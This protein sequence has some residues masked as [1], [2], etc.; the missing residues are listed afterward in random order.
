MFKHEL[1]KV[2][3]NKASIAFVIVVFIINIFQL[4]W[5]EDNSYWYP[6]EAYCS[7]WDDLRASAGDS[8]EGWQSAVDGLEAEI[9]KMQDSHYDISVV[10]S[11]YTGSLYHDSRLYKRVIAEIESTLGY[12]EYLVEIELTKKRY[13]ALGSLVDR[14]NYV[15]RNLMKSATLYEGLRPIELVLEQS[16]GVTMATGSDVTDFLAFALFL[17]F[18]INVW[19]KEKEQGM[20]GVIRTAKNGRARLA[21]TKIVTL[22]MVCVSCSALL[23]ISNM[24]IAEKYYGLGDLSRSIVTVDEYRGTLWRISVKDFLTYNLAFKLVTFVWLALFMSIICVGV[25]GSMAAFGTIAFMCAGS[26]ALYTK[27][28]ALSAWAVFKYLNPFGII[29]TELIFQEFRG[30]NIFGWPFDYRKC[31]AVMLVTGFILFAF[32]TVRLFVRMPVMSVN[33]FAKLTGRVQAVFIK[34]RRR[35]ECHVSITGHEFHRIFV[36]G[37]II[38]VVLVAL[39]I[40]VSS[41]KAY[42][43]GYSSLSEYF[44]R[45]YLEELSGAVTDEKVAFIASEEERLLRPKDENG[46]EQKKAL[47]EIQSRLSYLEAHEGT[48]FV[49]D[50]P[51]NK[52][53]AAD[54]FN[55]DLSQAVLFIIL[56]A[57]SMPLFFAPEWQTGMRKV[58]SVT[59]HGRRRLV[60]IRHVMGVLLVAAFFLITYLPPFIKIFKSYDMEWEKFAY[61]AGSLPHL[62]I[63]GTG[64]SIGTYMVLVYALRLAMGVLAALFIYKLSA[65][66]KSH[67]YTM[68]VA[69]IMLIPVLLASIDY[70][71]E[72]VAYPLSA[73][74]GNMAMQS[75]MAALVCATTATL[76]TLV[77]WI[78]N[79][80]RKV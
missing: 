18:G 17:F 57:L 3:C 20:L 65:L 45:Y 12:E 60:N 9:E 26:Y 49:Y 43:V 40:Q 11:K 33:Y 48:Y 59:L 68:V 13:E 73:F 77:L 63:F 50:E 35:L 7:L 42:T 37:G 14:D 72:F 44:E 5:L 52:L 56:L 36:S 70:K 80:R 54:R 53:T 16:A 79:K 41:N 8:I 46:Q 66:I 71:L 76:V 78:L 27:I 24:V 62:E 34:A 38:L 15:Y 39:V 67:V 74:A 51:F 22:V 64:M 19:L 29:K 61:P 30:I 47:M 69:F 55:D 25:A 75:G 6:K 2:V 10:P 28:P 31:V 1:Y 4:I 32:V 21:L 23:Y 58:V